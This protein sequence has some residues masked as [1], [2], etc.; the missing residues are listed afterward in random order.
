MNQN[1]VIPGTGQMITLFKSLSSWR[2]YVIITGLFLFFFFAATGRPYGSGELT[3][4]TGGLQVPDMSFVYTAQSV[5]SLL[6]SYGQ[7]GRDL[8]L[9]KIIPLDSV[10]ALVYLFFFA[11][12]QG[13]LIRYLFPARPDL[14]GLMII[15]VIGSLADIGEN[16]CFTLILLAYPA[17]LPLVVASASVITKLKFVCNFTAILLIAVT[18]VAAIIIG[19]H[20]LVTRNTIS[21]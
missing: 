11:I 4:I 18:L 12:T 20:R 21:R 13:I 3:V 6:D 5:Y 14:Q 16:I 2:F 7:T 8:Y 17:H 9:T 10:F 15:P 1:L 19:T